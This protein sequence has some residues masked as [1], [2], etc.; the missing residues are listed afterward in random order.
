MGDDIK[1]ISKN[2]KA[3]HDYLIE[4]SYEA[5]I[6]LQGSEV[7]SLRL[8]NCN[9][10]DSFVFIRNNTAELIGMHISPYDKGS[11]YNPE[12]MRSRQLLLNRK[13]IAKLRTAVEQKSYTIVPLKIYF[14]KAL[15]K[16]EIG[17][18]KGKDLYDKRQ[19]LKDKQL[20]RETE[21]IIKNFR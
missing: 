9:L 14:H 21:R 13:E 15:V 11:V 5:G 3:F 18:A 7:K 16:V 8:G 12:P 2:K 1:I 10:R 19:T 20:D 6:V 17:L 4:D